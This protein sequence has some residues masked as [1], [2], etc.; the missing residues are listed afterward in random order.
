MNDDL[1][2]LNDLDLHAWAAAPPPRNLADAVIARVVATEE[3]I[4]VTARRRMRR[5]A[6]AG[7]A[8]AT[9]LAAGVALWLGLRGPAPEPATG[10]DVVIAAVP[11]HVELGGIGADLDRGAAIRI[12]RGGDTLHVVQSGTARWD[13]P[14]AETLVIDAGSSASIE[15]TGASLRVETQMNLS[16]IR[17]ASS[18]ALTAA[19]VALATVTVYEGHVKA[20]SAGQTVVVQPHDTVAIELARAP[21]VIAQLDEL[22]H[23]IAGLRP[24]PPSASCDAAAD[25]AAG[26][27]AVANG[28]HRKGMAL[29]ASAWRCKPEPHTLMLAFMAACNSGSLEPARTYWA[30]MPHETQERLIAMC[31]RNHITRAQLDAPGAA[32]P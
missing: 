15:A 26:D 1:G 17:I 8:L 20:T 23:E 29:Y 28:D 7:G 25:V 10:D 12:H 27:A 21:K 14:A 4:A 19:A 22:E 31:T 18:A 5:Y 13:V 11:R 6:V 16:D 9:A 30:L 32:R 3:A 2:D 24:Q